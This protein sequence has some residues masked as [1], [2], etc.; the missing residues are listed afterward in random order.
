MMWSQCM[1]DMKTWMVA[2]RPPWRATMCSPNGRA[3]LPM[4]QTKYSSGAASLSSISTHEEWPPK[5][6]DTAKPS[7]RSAKAC[8]FSTVSR[9]RPFAATSARARRS[10]TSRQV[11][12]TGSEPRVPQ[13]RT[14]T[15]AL[16]AVEGGRG[17]RRGG[18]QRIAHAGVDLEQHAEAA[19]LED[20]GH[21]RAHRGDQDLAALRARLLARQHEAAQAGG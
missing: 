18:V 2:G 4:S 10:R 16:S 15:A 13:K 8:A 11:S 1:W 6:C 17:L 21:Q 14:R 19:D 5:V 9:L 12:A 3:P 20:L 7:S